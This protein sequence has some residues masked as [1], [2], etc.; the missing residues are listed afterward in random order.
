MLGHSST[1]IHLQDRGV[2][3]VKAVKLAIFIFLGYFSGNK[4]FS[5]IYNRWKLHCSGHGLCR[6]WKAL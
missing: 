4:A 5:Y 3:R 6:P 2:F 1:S